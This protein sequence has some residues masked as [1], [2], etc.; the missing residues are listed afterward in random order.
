MILVTLLV[1]GQ[2]QIFDEGI[3]LG[4]AASKINMTGAGATCTAQSYG[5]KCDFPGGGGGG[6]GGAPVDATYITQTANSTLTNEQALSSLS[7]GLVSVT[8]GTGVLSS[9]AGSTC[10]AGQYANSIGATGGLVCQQVV[11]SQIAST[12]T[13]PADISGASYWTK[14]AEAGLSNE[15]A[16]GTLGTGL[17]INT[18]TTGVP[19]IYSGTS[20]TNQFPRSLN[21]SGA[22]TCASVS[23]TSDVTGTL[24][25]GNGGTGVT[26]TTDDNVLVANGSA[27][28]SKTLPSCSNATTSKLLYDTSTN[29][30]S[31]GTDQT[32]GGGGGAGTLYK[33][34]GSNVTN[35]TTTPATITDLSWNVTSGTEYGFEC[36]LLMQGTSTSLPRLNI[37]GPATTHVAFTTERFTSTSAQTLLVLQ[38]F[39]A[40]AQTAACTSSCNATILPTK[41][42]G[43]V[44]PSASGTMAVQVTSST[45]GQVVTVYRGSYCVVF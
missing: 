35:S 28:Q 34:T 43:A 42:R 30:F 6:S 8:T 7:T 5:V 24:G 18:T 32:G 38:A 45:A 44:L 20:C 12:P 29:T 26:T 14:V 33:V 3:S 39:S 22:A 21:A 1:L 19:T 11:Y 2:V 36:V 9:Y 10:A 25:A 4:R 16:L 40:S 23:L 31:C 13:I 15:V 41:I 37:N 27:W 17:I